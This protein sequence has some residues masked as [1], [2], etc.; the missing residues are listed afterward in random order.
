ML[1]KVSGWMFTAQLPDGE[2][3]VPPPCR[4]KRLLCLSTCACGWARL[5]TLCSRSLVHPAL[6]SPAGAPTA[7]FSARAPS[8]G[9]P[10]HA[11]VR[12]FL[13]CSRRFPRRDG[14]ACAIGARSSPAA[15]CGESRQTAC[16]M[17]SGRPRVNSKTLTVNVVIA[18][19]P[20]WGEEARPFSSTSPQGGSEKG[21][22]EKRLLLDDFTVSVQ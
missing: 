3:F 14:S 1:E 22:P 16:L 9:F 18:S 12:S 11:C 6:E 20:E 5:Q 4:P 2:L 21:D 13:V 10:P 7:S 19:L 17:S 15:F 8:S